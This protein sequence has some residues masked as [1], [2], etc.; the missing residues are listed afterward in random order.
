MKLTLYTHVLTWS[1]AVWALSSREINSDSSTMDIDSVE[2][3]NAFL[4]IVDG[5]HLNETEST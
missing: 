2:S 3:L 5:S 4:C 1:W